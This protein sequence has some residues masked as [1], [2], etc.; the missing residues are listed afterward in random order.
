MARAKKPATE[1][2]APKPAVAEKPAPKKVK[3][4]AAEKPAVEKAAPKKA[5]KKAPAAK[6]WKPN[7]VTTKAALIDE[8]KA[9]MPNVELSAKAANELVDNLFQILGASIRKNE[10]F[11]VPGFGTFNLKKRKA[12]KGRNPQTGEQI[13]IKA[14]KTV[15]FK[16]T[17]KY[18]DSL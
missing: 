16:P 2:P 9:S 18:R 1:T 12:R 8:L 7:P 13:K 11:S 3:K 14:S 6:A 5:A 17:P 15:A 10:R 4:A